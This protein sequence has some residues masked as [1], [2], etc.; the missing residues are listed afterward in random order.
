VLNNNHSHTQP[1]STNI[2]LYEKNSESEYFFQQHWESEMFF[3]K[4][5]ITPPPLQA[6]WSVPNPTT[7]SNV[8]W[9]FAAKA[10]QRKKKLALCP[11]EK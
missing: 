6:K 1:N 7:G 10:C 8:L 9:E 4:K 5:N 3:R 11:T 2:R